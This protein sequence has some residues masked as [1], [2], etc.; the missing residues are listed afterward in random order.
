MDV[1]DANTSTSKIFLGDR[2]KYNE[3]IFNSYITYFLGD[4]SKVEKISNYEFPKNYFIA[5]Y[6]PQ[7]YEKIFNIKAKNN[8]SS[9]KYLENV[10]FDSGTLGVS[11]NLSELKEAGPVLDIMA[12]YGGDFTRGLFQEC[13]YLRLDLNFFKM[14]IICLLISEGMLSIDDIKY[15]IT[16]EHI[17]F[18]KCI[19]IMVE[20]LEDDTKSLVSLDKLEVGS[21]M[22]ANC[23]NIKSFDYELPSLRE[24]ATMFSGSG[25]KIWNKNLPS[26]ISSTAK[27]HLL[28]TLFSCVEMEKP[29]ASY[30]EKI[31]MTEILAND[32]Y[33]ILE[34]EYLFTKFSG[35]FAGCE[36]LESFSGDCK[37]LIDG[38][39][40]FAACASLRNFTGYLPSLRYG[41]NMFDECNLSAESVLHILLSLPYN[42]SVWNINDFKNE[43][44][45]P[46]ITDCIEGVISIGINTTEETKDDFAQEIGFDTFEELTNAFVEKNW[47][48]RWIFTGDVG[49]TYSLRGPK[50]SNP[51]YVSISEIKKDVDF[52]DKSHE[53]ISKYLNL[54][55]EILEKAY[56]D[57]KPQYQSED[58]KFYNMHVI[59]DSNNL[60][61]YTRF[62][63]LEDALEHYKLTPYV[64][65]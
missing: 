2:L 47:T 10:T 41:N 17:E 32:L 30:E 53:K 7:N 33:D 58:G 14:S 37:S 5:A 27:I 34:M 44:L 49:S 42:N 65:N 22:F 15:G 62:D 20:M 26:L 31:E 40:M 12:F 54:K 3:E 11:L 13:E 46:L 39:G 35:M 57:I 38:R 45:I 6:V 21:A 60:K 43:E 18:V 48:V 52:K 1:I 16:D 61:G 19:R 25:I 36:S 64:E 24:G 59:S 23:S 63:S 51:V 8:T 29:D 55:P 4:N 28:E 50:K 56:K 9:L